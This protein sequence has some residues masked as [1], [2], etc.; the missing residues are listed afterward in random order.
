MC[1]Y[2]QGRP[3]VEVNWYYNLNI[4]VRAQ[5]LLRVFAAGEDFVALWEIVSVNI[6]AEEGD[7]FCV[8]VDIIDDDEEEQ[9]EEFKIE[10][11]VFDINAF[12]P[13]D[14]RMALVH[15]EDNDGPGMYKITN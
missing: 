1:A 5:L 13:F 12:V 14:S 8:Y 7:V 4:N 10:I 9:Y 11:E 6:N 3:V 15:I 2:S